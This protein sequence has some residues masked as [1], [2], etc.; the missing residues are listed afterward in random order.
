MLKNTIYHV[1]FPT[2]CS[3]PVKLLDFTFC[4][5]QKREGSVCFLFIYGY[6]LRRRT[7]TIHSSCVHTKTSYKTKKHFS[8]KGNLLY[9]RKKFVKKQEEVKL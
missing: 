5:L 3:H 4:F 8:L 6:I 1:F 9:V 2:I 7:P